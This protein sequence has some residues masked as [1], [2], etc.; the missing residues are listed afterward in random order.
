MWG[1]REQGETKKRL[2]CEAKDVR[3]MQ[4]YEVARTKKAQEPMNVAQVSAISQA[5]LVEAKPSA[6]QRVKPRAPTR[7]QKPICQPNCLGAGMY[8]LDWVSSMKSQL[9]MMKPVPPTTCET[10]RQRFWT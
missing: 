4:E 8:H 9:E 2:G 7:F 1:G 6:P 3:R 5:E 10:A